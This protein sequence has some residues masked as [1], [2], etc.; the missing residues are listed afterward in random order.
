MNIHTA[1]GASRLSGVQARLDKGKTTNFED[2]GRPESSGGDRSVGQRHESHQS[3]DG[4]G[5]RDGHGHGGHGPSHGGKGKLGKSLQRGNTQQNLANRAP[6]SRHQSNERANV[7]VTEGKAQRMTEQGGQQDGQQGAQ[8]DEGPREYPKSGVFGMS[9]VPVEKEPQ[10]VLHTISILA[11]GA[12][13]SMHKP[14]D[15]E[16]VAIQ[17]RTEKEKGAKEERNLDN[18]LKTRLWLD[19]VEDNEP[20]V[21]LPSQKT[22]GI[23]M[24]AYR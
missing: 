19:D 21:V 24:H 11:K 12:V 18:V 9:T 20:F 16:H 8:Q 10:F 7:R 13:A 3:H 17:T 4:H 1:L 6:D 22:E 23:R 2:E 14:E 5:G 15:V